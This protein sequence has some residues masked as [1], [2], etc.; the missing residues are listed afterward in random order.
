MKMAKPA[1]TIVRRVEISTIEVNS[2]PIVTQ[3]MPAA[4]PPTSAGT[5]CTRVLG[6]SE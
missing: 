2:L 5:C 1:Y 3:R 6:M 4:T